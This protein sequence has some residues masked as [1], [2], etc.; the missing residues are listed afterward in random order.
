MMLHLQSVLSQLFQSAQHCN[1]VLDVH[2]VSYGGTAL[3]WITAVLCLPLSWDSLTDA[4]NGVGSVL[5]LPDDSRGTTKLSEKKK[6]DSKTVRQAEGF[7]SA[8]VR[9]YCRR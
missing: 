2:P 4:C 9:A 8:P 1:A 3:R 5:Q 7:L 6:K